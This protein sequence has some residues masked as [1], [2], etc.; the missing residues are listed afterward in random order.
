MT[1]PN[2]AASGEAMARSPKMIKRIDHTIDGEEPRFTTASGVAP[3]VSPQAK[4]LVFGSLVYRLKPRMPRLWLSTA[5][6]H[7]P[8]AGFQGSI[9]YTF[10]SV[11]PPLQT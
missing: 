6:Q 1:T 4:D 11:G 2:E 7:T 10:F 9:F 8:L 5:P 3:I